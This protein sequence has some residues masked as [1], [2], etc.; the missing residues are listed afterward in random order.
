[1][2][3][4]TFNVPKEILK[5]VPR[6]VAFRH[7]VLPLSRKGTTL[8]VATTNPHNLTVLDEL[9]F[10]TGLNIEGVFAREPDLVQAIQKHYALRYEEARVQVVGFGEEEVSHEELAKLAE[11]YLD[12][13][14]SEVD[15]E[16][17]EVVQEE[18]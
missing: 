13:M 2:F 10:R 15:L 3:E 9:R 1:M 14:R 5:Y 7:T 12:I 8:R 4:Q 18:R 16:S 17:V 6:E 11:D